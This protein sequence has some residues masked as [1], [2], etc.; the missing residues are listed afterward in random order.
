MGTS[1][2]FWGSKSGLVPSWADE[3][4]AS[5][6]APPDGD[7]EGT[8]D[9]G[10]DGNGDAEPTHAAPSPYPPLPAIPVWVGPSWCTRQYHERGADLGYRGDSARSRTVCECQRRRSCGGTADGEFSSR[11]R[12]H[13]RSCAFFRHSGSSRGVTSI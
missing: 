2:P 10:V 1:G 3:P 5:P 6:T 8:Q 13:R 7:G 12:R 9:D 11:G 4:A